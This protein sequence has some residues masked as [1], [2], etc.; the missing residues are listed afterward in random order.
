MLHQFVVFIAI[1][2]HTTNTIV[3]TLEERLPHIDD[4]IEK[5]NS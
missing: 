5:K 3:D 1:L 4:V 2:K